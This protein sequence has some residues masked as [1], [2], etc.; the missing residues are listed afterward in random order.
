VI[1]ITLV[2]EEFLELGP[3]GDKS[4]NNSQRHWKMVVAALIP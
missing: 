1:Q 4:I 3:Q 2:N